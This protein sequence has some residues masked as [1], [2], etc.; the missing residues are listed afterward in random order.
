MCQCKWWFHLRDPLL[1]RKWTEQPDTT[2]KVKLFSSIS[3]V[4]LIDHRIMK[5][6]PERHKRQL[7]WVQRWLREG[8][9]E[10][11]SWLPLPITGGHLAN[12]NVTLQPQIKRCKTKG[13]KLGRW[14]STKVEFVRPLRMRNTEGAWRVIVNDIHVYRL[15]LPHPPNHGILILILIVPDI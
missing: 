4:V 2:E 11:L 12:R 8:A 3:E 14:F 13:N 10:P 6:K 15:D 9:L 7:C 1:L 5:I